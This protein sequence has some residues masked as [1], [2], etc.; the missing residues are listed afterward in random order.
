MVV[1]V[2]A[3]DGARVVDGMRGWRSDLRNFGT[4]V[5][6]MMTVAGCKD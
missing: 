1:I 3:R 2:K 6:N 4:P 5:H